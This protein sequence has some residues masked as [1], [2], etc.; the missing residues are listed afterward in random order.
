[1]TTHLPPCLA[2]PLS[3]SALARAALTVRDVTKAWPDGDA[4]RSRFHLRTAT[5]WTAMLGELQAAV[6]DVAPDG[7]RDAVRAANVTAAVLTSVC[8]HRVPTSEEV[9]RE[10]AAVLDR[11]WA[12]SGADDAESRRLAHG[13]RRLA[14]GASVTGCTELAA[15]MR[16]RDP[17]LDDVGV[18][19]R[20]HA[21]LSVAATV[22]RSDDA[23]VVAALI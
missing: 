5:F 2:T 1:M 8:A 12:C 19:V 14:D 4:V 17:E 3:A 23:W 18:E 9:E 13:V 11:V 15:A 20:V 10:L 7:G 21:A 16:G 22:D 6:R